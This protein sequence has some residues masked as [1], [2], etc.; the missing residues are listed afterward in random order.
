MMSIRKHIHSSFPFPFIAT[1]PCNQFASQDPA[2][3]EGIGA[4]C[5]KNYGVS[6]VSVTLLDPITDTGADFYIHLS[7]FLA[8]R[9]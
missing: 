8:H 5:Q 7:P 6:F 2:D 4:F 3:D 1:V 9:T